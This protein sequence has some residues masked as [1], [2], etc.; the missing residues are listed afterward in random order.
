MK[1]IGGNLAG[2]GVV[3][4][5]IIIIGRGPQ[6]VI[7]EHLEETGQNPTAWLPSIEAAISKIQRSHNG[8]TT[9]SMIATTCDAAVVTEEKKAD[10]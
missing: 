5:G 10:A 6:G 1:G 8:D 7:F 9:P 2:E 4:G 3:Q